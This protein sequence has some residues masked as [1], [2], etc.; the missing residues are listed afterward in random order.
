MT[1]RLLRLADIVGSKRKKTAGLIPVHEATWFR[2][3]QSGR[4]PPPIKFG[5]ISCWPESTIKALMESGI[6]KE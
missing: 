2:W 1:D 6:G 5:H 4:V 3:V